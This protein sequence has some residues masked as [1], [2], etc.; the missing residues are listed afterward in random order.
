LQGHKIKYILGNAFYTASFS[1]V[2]FDFLPWFSAAA[3]LFE[4][5][6]IF[7]LYFEFRRRLLI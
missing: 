3:A 7:F 1:A 5:G 4:R 6:C 2:K